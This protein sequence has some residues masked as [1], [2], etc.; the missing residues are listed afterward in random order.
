FIADGLLSW[1]RRHSR[2]SGNP[3]SSVGGVHRPDRGRESL[4]LPLPPNRTGGSPAYGSPVGGFTWLRI[5]EW[6]HQAEEIRLTSHDTYSTVS[7]R[8]V[9]NM[10]NFDRHSVFRLATPEAVPTC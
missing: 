7:P 6:P 3:E 5:D 8:G 1:N 2:E 4:L 9:V 10:R